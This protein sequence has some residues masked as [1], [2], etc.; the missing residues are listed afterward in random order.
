MLPFALI[1][2]VGLLPA[3]VGLGGVQALQDTPVE[4]E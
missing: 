1:Q 3:I 2:V 4:T